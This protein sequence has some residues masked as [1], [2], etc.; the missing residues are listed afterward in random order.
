MRSS[1]I[2]AFT[3]LGWVLPPFGSCDLAGSKIEKRQD[4]SD[5]SFP[6][7]TTDPP[8]SQTDSP[9]TQVPEPSSSKFSQ[10]SGGTSTLSHTSTTR[11]ATTTN[12][13]PAASSAAANNS[14]TSSGQ[15]D[16]N[17]LP[18]HP[19]ITP[20]LGIAGVF[21]IALGA[22]Y[23][24]IGV[25][26]RGV[27]IFLS[28]A[29]LAS[30]AT[31]AL[32]GYVMNPPVSNAIQGGFFVAIF[33]TGAVF[34]GGALIFKELT[35]GLGC[36]LGGFCFS[37][38]LLTLK[39]GGLITSSGGK[40]AFIGGFCVVAWALS[41][42]QYTRPYALIGSTS[43]SGA[44]A[45]VLGLDCFT[46]AGMK[47]F[48]F[49]IW[50][51]N[52][53][54]FPLDTNTYPLTKGMK[55]EIAVIV[56]GTMIGIL[57][58]IKM[59]KIIR[60]KQRQGEVGK[61]EGER[62]REAVEAALGRHLQRQNERE[63]SEWERQY[64]DRLQSKR[65]TILWQDAHPEKRSSSVSVE[66]L[67][68]PSS[69]ADNWEVNALGPQR[70]SGHGPKYKRQSSVAVDVI[71]EVE[72]DP[73][74]IAYTERQKA[75]QA[76]EEGKSSDER[77]RS[78]ESGGA[79]TTGFDQTTAEPGKFLEPSKSKRRSQQSLSNLSKCLGPTYGATSESREQ[80]LDVERPYSR[81]S[82]AAATLDEDNEDLD[83]SALDADADENKHQ[84]PEIII[85]PTTPNEGRLWGTSTNEP[86]NEENAS[87]SNT[88][89]NFG[90]ASRP[91]GKEVES[92]VDQSTRADEVA[93][94]SESEAGDG[95][96]QS[97]NYSRSQA[98][99][100]TNS[101]ADSLTQTALA[102]IPN[103]LSN[104]VLSY[105]TNEWAKHIATAEAPICDEP[106]S[107]DNADELPTQ[108]APPPIESEKAP[109]NEPTIEA[110]PAEMLPPTVQ[111]GGAGVGIA[112]NPAANHRRF[113][114]PQRRRSV[115]KAPSR[116][117]SS[118][119]LKLPGNRSS[120]NSFNPVSTT[121]LVTTPIDENVPTEFTASKI[122]TRR[123]S[124]GSPYP[125]AQRSS[126][127]PVLT[128]SGMRPYTSHGSA[129]P[130]ARSTYDLLQLSRPASHHTHASGLVTGTRL[131][132]YNSRQP[133]RRDTRNDAERRESL[134]AEWRLSQQHHARSSGL[135]ETSAEAGRA[136]MKMEKENQ[137]LLEEHQ[138]NAQQRKQHVMDQVMRRPDMQ[139]LHREAMR[140]MQANANQK[141]RN[142]T[143]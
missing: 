28:A 52:G 60:S 4:A 120:R 57:S 34:G 44:T 113:S 6:T 1:Q 15:D 10:T 31:T 80:L 27:Q 72:E 40:G 37:M 89:R 83:V 71:E 36:L 19:R 50:N 108:L 116:S 53:D 69:S 99:E 48:W 61:E 41:W 35:E 104:V 115:I 58:Q 67:G 95:T 55:I 132:S 141:L 43:F 22:V 119:S 14:T 97:N 59:W 16:K 107:I 137:K 86:T 133:S 45:F 93:H 139:E 136:Q 2:V 46:R 131:E 39:P 18:L 106:E 88:A 85:S 73:E 42:I 81:A 79:V 109:P 49:H 51:L 127:S 54:L 138:R 62:Q 87:S 114:D 47:E 103:Q 140:K 126:S 29:F 123:A 26:S 110:P 8:S 21:L 134:L 74:A 64:G 121:S 24:L 12:A 82:S 122:T 23:A 90:A 17:E 128:S 38:W 118:Q 130:H 11:V 92:A 75:L 9:S 117:G 20:A 94:S 56:I 96:K 98:S 142:S 76:L 135:N 5:T 32:V 125:M 124:G 101:S 143:G 84:M 3:L 70:P 105:R 66:V 7:L 78:G 68:A 102:Q 77:K 112:S 111:A 63:K 91:E 33:M 129:S 65:H 13:T 100:G 25:K 30:T